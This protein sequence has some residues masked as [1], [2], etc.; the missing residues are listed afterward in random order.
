MG[1]REAV[2]LLDGGMAAGLLRRDAA[3]MRRLETVAPAEVCISAVTLSELMFGVAM[4]REQE[5]DKAALDEFLL[6]VAVLEYMREAAE[7]YGAIREAL[8]WREV[9]MGPHEMLIAAHA[10]SRGLRLVTERTKMF[11]E[12]PGL[13]IEP[14]TR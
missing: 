10:R 14:W 5:R 8:T 6:H 11:R 12:I 1:R 4:S 2:F 13:E 9:K 7:E 3:M